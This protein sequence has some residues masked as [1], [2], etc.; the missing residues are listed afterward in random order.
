MTPG[1]PPRDQPP[2]QWLTVDRADAAKA[3]CDGALR[4][5]LA[6]FLLCERSI[7]EVAAELGQPKNAVLLKVRRL[8]KLG[9]L[10][11]VREQPRAGRA[12][13]FYQAV[14]SGFFVPYHLT[15][16]PTPEAWMQAE[17]AR[18]EQALATQTMQAGQR[19][20]QAQGASQF[21][22]RFFMR[23]D[24]LAEADFAFDMQTPADMQAADAPAVMSLFVYTHLDRETA[25]QLQAELDALARRY[26]RPAGGEVYLLRL[27]LAPL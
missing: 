20:Q 7:G 24:G 21:G 4:E 18:R 3:L 16:Y 6:A 17:Y 2:S 13:K 22:L 19:W 8:Q 9:L 15:P 25:K 26:E 14:Q 10:K 23:A 5:V 27:G 1:T 11:V 12:I